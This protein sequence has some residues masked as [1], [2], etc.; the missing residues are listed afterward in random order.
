MSTAAQASDHG[1]FTTRRE[2]VNVRRSLLRLTA[3]GIVLAMPLVG[4]SGVAS[5]KSA[6]TA[7]AKCHKHPNKA[8]C[9]NAGGGGTGGSPAPLEINVQVDPQPVILTGQSEVHVIVQVSA[10]PAYAGDA[11]NI[12]SSQLTASCTGGVDFETLQVPGG[13]PQLVPPLVLERVNRAE[14][15]LDDDGNA[16]VVMDGAECA[17]GAD[18]IEADLEA[19]PFVTA[20]TTL[21]VAPP[22]ITPPGITVAPR[23]GGLDQEIETGDTSASGDSDV[24]IVFYVETN[25]VYAEQTVEIGSA[26]LEARCL[27]GWLWQGENQTPAVLHVNSSQSGTGV[28]TGSKVQTTLDDDGNAVFIFEGVS[29]AAGPSQVIADVLA[30]SHPTYTTEYTVLAPTPTI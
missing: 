23:T 15:I 10:L 19:A 18:V 5:A 29:C 22:N 11:V 1:L 8:K 2:H 12:D 30:G 27:Q 21:N 9:K 26:Q 16:T 25:P 24:Y 17:P 14:V 4:V 7:A 3:L 6:K 20:I 28:N 13:G